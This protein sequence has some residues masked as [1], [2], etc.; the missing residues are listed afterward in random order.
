MPKLNVAISNNGR[1]RA[2]K[3]GFRARF[4]SW[5]SSSAEENFGISGSSLGCA[6]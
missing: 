2:W 6:T 4:H 1:H 5:K 3:F